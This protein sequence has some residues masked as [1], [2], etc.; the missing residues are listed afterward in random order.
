M[1]PRRLHAAHTAKCA[2]C[3]VRAEKRNPAAPRHRCGRTKPS[4]APLPEGC[5]FARRLSQALQYRAR[6]T[7]AKVERVMGR[8]VRVCLGIVTDARSALKLPAYAV[9]RLDSM[10]CN[11]ARPFAGFATMGTLY[12][13]DATSAQP[14]SPSNA[15]INNSR[16]RRRTRELLT[17][18]SPLPAS[19]LAH[20]PLSASRLALPLFGL[21]RSPPL[22]SLSSSP[23]DVASPGPPLRL[24]SSGR[25]GGGVVA[26][27]LN[28][29]SPPRRPGA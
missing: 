29:D 13:S 12:R 8:D 25:E 28:R 14:R 2:L 9:S 20:P 17:P 10:C 19:S 21:F 4:S 15:S 16:V 11:S 1:D 26:G 3:R 5:H 23:R 24:S 7:P 27:S 18:P 22:E 6:V